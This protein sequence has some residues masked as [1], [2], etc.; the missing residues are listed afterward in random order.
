MTTMTKDHR[1]PLYA[2]HPS[3]SGADRAGSEGPTLPADRFN[4][5]LAI[6]RSVIGVVF[7]AHGAQKL[8]VFGFAG[9]TGAFGEMGVPL[10]GLVGP[11]VALL[12]FFGGL[13]LIT[14]LYTRSAALGLS[15]VMLGALFVAHLPAGFF[16]PDG[17]EFVLTLCAATLA[18]ALSGPGS[19]SLD[20]LLRQHR[21]RT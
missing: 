11:A 20:H 1:Y 9:V 4:A 12:E 18:L 2:R 8:F 17:I 5:G 6:L 19:Y 3:P 13:A 21:A 16:A 7:L 14:G 15:L 10:A